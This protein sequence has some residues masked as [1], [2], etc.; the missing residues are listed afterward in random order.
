MFNAIEDKLGMV[1]NMMRT[2]ANSPAVL[3][4][5]LS[6][7]G[8]LGTGKLGAK[9]GEL[10]AIAVAE[11]NACEYCLSAHTFIGTN[12]MKMNAETLVSARASNSADA[13][14]HAVLTFASALVDKKGLVNDNDVNTAKSAGITDQELSEVVGHVALNI[15]TNYFNNA[16]GTHNDFPAVKVLETSQR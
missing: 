2:M 14:T 4:G 10:I 7:S 12:L 11:R 8:A 16:A 13:K 6:L 3:E 9:T 5:Y 1:P 15:L